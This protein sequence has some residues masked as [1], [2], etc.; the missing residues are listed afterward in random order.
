MTTIRRIKLIKE[1]DDV[2]KHKIL[3]GGTWYVSET[4]YD[5]YHD[6]AK[7]LRRVREKQNIK[8]AS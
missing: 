1:A 6:A 4:V 3:I 2:F 5:N 7:M 8:K